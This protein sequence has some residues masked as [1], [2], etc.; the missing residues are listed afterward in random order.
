MNAA[1]WPRSS[2]ER[3]APSSDSL[4]SEPGLIEHDLRRRARRLH[5]RSPLTADDD[6]SPTRSPSSSRFDCS[7]S[8]T[9]ARTVRTPGSASR[10]RLRTSWP[11]ARPCDVR[12]R[13]QPEDVLGVRRIDGRVADDAR[14]AR[15]RRRIDGRDRRRSRRCPPRRSDARPARA[16]RPPQRRPPCRRCRARAERPCARRRGRRRR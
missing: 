8:P 4:A 10:M 14:D 6:C 15:A 7:S 13:G 5:R 2:T 12:V 16:W 3:R 9:S 1:V 11:K